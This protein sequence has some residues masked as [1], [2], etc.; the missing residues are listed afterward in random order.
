MDGRKKSSCLI[1]DYSPIRH[2]CLRLIVFKKKI[3]LI[4][5]LQAK[6]RRPVGS[7]KIRRHTEVVLSQKGVLAQTLCKPIRFGIFAQPSRVF[8]YQCGVLHTHVEFVR[9]RLEFVHT[10]VEFVLNHVE[11]V[12]TNGEFELTNIEFTLTHLEFVLNH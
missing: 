12:H 3:Q 9:T 7:G 6:V 1:K 11:F 5:S 8:A 10:S 2:V 4:G